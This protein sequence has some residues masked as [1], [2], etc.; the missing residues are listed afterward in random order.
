MR[1]GTL[2]GRKLT[3]AGV[4]LSSLGLLVSGLYIQLVASPNILVLYLTVGVATGFGFG[5]MFL[6]AMDIVEHYFNR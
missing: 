6:P 4:F 3:L 5:L 1:C 2:C